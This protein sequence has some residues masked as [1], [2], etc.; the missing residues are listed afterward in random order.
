M[1]NKV[2]RGLSRHVQYRHKSF[3]ASKRPMLGKVLITPK[4]SD[5][6]KVPRRTFLSKLFGGFSERN[7]GYT[8]QADD[9][10]GFIR[11]LSKDNPRQCIR[12][13]EGNNNSLLC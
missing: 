7:N 3:F 13:L 6:Q 10:I 11:Y 2:F 5:I 4:R 1:Y 12:T 9:A 8:G